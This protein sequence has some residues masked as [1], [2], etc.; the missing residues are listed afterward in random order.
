MHARELD[1]AIAFV[2]SR[3][4]FCDSLHT[5]SREWNS[6]LYLEIM[7]LRERLEGLEGLRRSIAAQFEQDGLA[8]IT[9]YIKRHDGPYLE[10]ASRAGLEK[11]PRALDNWNN[12]SGSP[13]SIGGIENIVDPVLGVGALGR[14]GLRYFLKVAAR[15]GVEAAARPLAR[16][17]AKHLGDGIRAADDVGLAPGRIFRGLYGATSREALETAARAGGSTTR[18][19]SLFWHSGGMSLFRYAC[20]ESADGD[21]REIERFR[22]N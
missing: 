22:G 2:R 20:W 18:V 17:S 21:C 1:A 11:I 5:T 7:A 13:E 12:V 15:E 3:L 16:N 4:F 8:D 10:S 19:H 9:L 6:D 14:L